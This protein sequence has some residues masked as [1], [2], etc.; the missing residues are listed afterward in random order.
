MS[1]RHILLHTLEH[2]VGSSAAGEQAIGTTLFAVAAGMHFAF[3]YVTAIGS[4]VFGW[5]LAARCKGT[6]IFKLAG[7]GWRSPAS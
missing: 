1:V 2:S 7:W 4:T 6:D 5:G 3:L